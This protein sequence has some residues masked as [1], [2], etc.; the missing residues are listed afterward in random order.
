MKKDRWRCLANRVEDQ[1][2]EDFPRATDRWLFEETYKIMRRGFGPEPSDTKYRGEVMGKIGA[3]W[4]W[5]NGKKTLIASILVGVPVIWEVVAAIL[6][7]GGV[8][9]DQIAAVG[10][11]ILLIVGWAH[12]LLKVAGLAKAPNR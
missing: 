12:K 6:Q 4:D 10:S 8:S 9:T 1:L 3:I 5:L 7:A 11:I 2:R